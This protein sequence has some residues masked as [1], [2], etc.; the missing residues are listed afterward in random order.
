MDWKMIGNAAAGRTTALR[1]ITRRM[2]IDDRAALALLLL[3]DETPPAAA[4]LVAAALQSRYDAPPIHAALAPHVAPALADWRADPQWANRAIGAAAQ[5]RL[6][7]D[8]AVM[9]G[10]LRA[11]PAALRDIVAIVLRDGDSA[12]VADCLEALGPAGWTTLDDDGRRTLLARARVSDVGRVWDALGEAQRAK[13]VE[14]AATAAY[15][16]AR[17]IGSIGAGA[18]TA[19]DPALRRVLIDAVARD[20]LWV[21]ATAPAWAGMTDD[22]RDDLARAA[23]ARGDEMDAFRLLGDLGAAG[24]A[25]LTVEQRAA[26]DGRAKRRP[27]GWRVLALRAADAGWTAL[28]DEERAVVMAQADLDGGSVRRLLRYVGV[29]GWRAMRADEQARLAAAVRRTQG[30]LFACPPAL[31]SDLAGAALPPATSILRDVMGYWIAEDAGADLGGLPPPHQAVVLALAPWRIEDAVP[32]SVRVQRLLGA[33]SEMP[34]NERVALIMEHLRV[35]TPVAAAVRLR[36]GASA[37]VD[38]VGA[39]VARVVTMTGGTAVTRDIGAMLGAPGDW[40][41]WM[42]AFAPTDAN[43]PD[44]WAA[45]IAAARRGS[46][47]DPALCARL[48]AASLSVAPP[49]RTLRRTRR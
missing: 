13:V 22:E 33:W 39:T 40:R 44:A 23:I 38:V 27:D 24:R 11:D 16:A 4:A 18:W 9:S 49:P 10:A 42:R 14:R 26:L 12:A 2:G 15:D 6:P 46:I 29:A 43:P 28:T 48:A 31:W 37:A 35:L 34:A 32:D 41:S 3:L 47:P 19:T 8:V 17:L 7:W 20:P 36:G 25:T 30:A 5:R 45:W 1:S 21:S